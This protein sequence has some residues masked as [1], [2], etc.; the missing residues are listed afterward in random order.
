MPKNDPK[1][2]Q[3]RAKQDIDSILENVNGKEAA[4]EKF[5]KILESIGKDYDKQVLENP[6]SRANAEKY[7]D[8]VKNADQALNQSYKFITDY[9]L[10]DKSEQIIDLLLEKA[11]ENNPDNKY[12]EMLYQRAGAKRPDLLPS[13]QEEY[14]KQITNNYEGFEKEVYTKA[15]AAFEKMKNI[16]E[17]KLSKESLSQ[18]SLVDQGLSLE[19][20]YL[21]QEQKDKIRDIGLAVNAVDEKE[22]P[23]K[24]ISMSSDPSGGVTDA[25]LPAANA[26]GKLMN[27]DKMMFDIKAYDEQWKKLLGQ[28]NQIGASHKEQIS[29]NKKNLRDYRLDGIIA[30]FKRMYNTLTKGRQEAK[31]IYKTEAGNRQY[32]TDKAIQNIKNNKKLYKISRKIQKDIRTDIA[33]E[34]N[35]VKDA[36]QIMT[37][38]ETKKVLSTVPEKKREIRNQ[39]VKDK[40]NKLESSVVQELGVSQGNRITPELQKKAEQLIDKKHIS[41]APPSNSR[42]TPIL[43]RSKSMPNLNELKR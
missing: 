19:S 20:L 1:N 15:K 39:Y 33:K 35:K 2:N 24:K 16:I 9:Q 14:K 7:D 4:K 32:N 43:T 29:Q 41:P 28:V 3:T 18:I 31:D 17:N 6:I 34:W 21:T 30:P 26:M 40:R 11:I 42:T 36:S 22:L 37:S 13:L 12:P 10:R 23:R 27:D 38:K 25:L 5:N 8:I